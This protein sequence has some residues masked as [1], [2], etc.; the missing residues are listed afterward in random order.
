MGCPE[1]DSSDATSTA[2]SLLPSD[3]IGGANPSPGRVELHRR[4]RPPLGGAE[5][6]FN[7]LSQTRGS[8]DQGAG[9][10]TRLSLCSIWRVAQAGY[11]DHVAAVVLADSEPEWSGT[12]ARRNGLAPEPASTLKRAPVPP[13]RAGFAN[14]GARTA[15]L[16]LLRCKKTMHI[17]LGRSLLAV[18]A[19][20]DGTSPLDGLGFTVV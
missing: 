13:N 17:Q 1:G 19:L 4:L 9:R 7:N 5:I 16:K 6:S 8:G 15:G 18:R 10:R 11:A 12:M 3:R 20:D 14:V 2:K